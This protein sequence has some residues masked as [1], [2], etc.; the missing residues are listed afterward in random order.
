MKKIEEKHLENE[1]KT[2]LKCKYL[3]RFQINQRQLHL[4]IDLRYL[5]TI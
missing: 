1:V 5:I 3:M 2:T 4:T